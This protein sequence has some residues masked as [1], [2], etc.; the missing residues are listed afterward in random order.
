MTKRQLRATVPASAADV[1]DRLDAQLSRSEWALPFR[2][3]SAR[4]VQH[5]RRTGAGR[6]EFEQTDGDFQHLRGAWSATD[7]ADGGCEVAFEV[8][9]STSVPHLAGAIDS[10]IGRVLVRTAH[11]IM[12]AS[13]GPVRVTAGGHHLRDLP[14]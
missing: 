10:A 4:W 9:F 8:N 11:Q 1:L 13:G 6:I 14:G 2:G 3:S 5:S 12:S 7:L